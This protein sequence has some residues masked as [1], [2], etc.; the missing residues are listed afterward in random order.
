MAEE[1][2]S[3][4]DALDMDYLDTASTAEAFATAANARKKPKN[5]L[6]LIDLER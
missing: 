3:S 5:A 6:E 1:T 4:L 2:E